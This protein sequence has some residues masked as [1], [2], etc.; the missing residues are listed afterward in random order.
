M[1]RTLIVSSSLSLSL[2]AGAAQ[3]QENLPT[4]FAL[5]SSLDLECRP[6]FG[7][8]PAPSVGVRQ[9]NPVLIPKIPPQQAQL[10]PLDEVCVPVAKNGQLPPPRALAINRWVDLACYDAVAA[11]INVD[12]KVSHLNPQLHDLPSEDVTM[13]RLEQ[14]CLPVMKNHVEPPPVIKQ[15]V[16]HFDF[17]CYEL[18]E[19]TQDHDRT[20]VLSH[21]NPVIQEMNLPN[22]IVEMKR[23]HQL[24]VPIAKNAQPVPPEVRQLVE[25]VDFLKYRVVPNQPPP[26]LPLW[27]GHLNP[28]YTEV[29]PFFAVLTPERIRL[30]V[31]V[32]KDGHIPPGQPND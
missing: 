4:P 14:V 22:R 20:L 9:L 10:G 19:P 3:A 23:A 29:N 27:L 5:A 13:V 16:A 1:F 32:A 6:A 2:F 25:W 28:L 30:M 21:L 17:G 15:F 11:P 31:P 8:P 18:A 24:C 26:A 12:V 7:P